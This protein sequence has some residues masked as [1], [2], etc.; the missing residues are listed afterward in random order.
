MISSSLQS[1]M[2]LAESSAA[3]VA[4]SYN[5]QNV[6]SSLLAYACSH[7]SPLAAIAALLALLGGTGAVVVLLLLVGVEVLGAPAIV[8]L[9]VPAR[10][11]FPS[12]NATLAAGPLLDRLG[13]ALKA[14]PGGLQVLAYT[15]NQR[16]R[17]VGFPSNFALSTAQAK[18]VQ[19]ALAK[20]TGEPAR[21]SAEGRADADPLAPNGTPEGRERNRRI[22]LVL[23]PPA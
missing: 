17:S 1:A 20:Q 5:E 23:T 10:L 18:A 13:A 14:E 2:S 12:G 16:R 7:C 22:D 3:S 19:A 11:L 4:G 8:T 6:A 21:M 9:R 15:D